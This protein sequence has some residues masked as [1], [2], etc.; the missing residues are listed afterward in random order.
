VSGSLVDDWVR[1]TIGASKMRI[2]FAYRLSPS[3][4]LYRI[5]SHALATHLK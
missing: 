1:V 3:R 4:H 5:S 2:E